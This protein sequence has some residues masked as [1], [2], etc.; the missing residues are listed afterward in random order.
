MLSIQT[1][2]NSLVAQENLSVNSKFQSQTIQRLTSGYRINSAGD[3]AAGLAVANQFRD[4]VAE[5]TQGVRNA[6][7]GVSQL[8]IID[9]GLSNISNI[10]DRLQTLATESSSTSFTGDRSTLNNEY[11]SLL[12][13]I[14]RQSTNIKLN[15]GG[16]LTSQWQVYIGG[17]SSANS[18]AMV[19][20]NLGTSPVDTLGLNLKGTSILG[21][22]TGFANNVVRM[23]DTQAKFDSGTVDPANNEVFT[24]NYTDSTGAAQSSNVTMAARAGGYSGTD[25]V[26]ALNLAIHADTTGVSAQIGGDG[27]LQFIGSGAFTVSYAKNGTVSG[28][29][30]AGAPGGTAVATNLTNS[31]NYNVSKAF[32]PFA[33]TG[34]PSTST[35]LNEVAQFTTGGKNYS[36]TLSSDS[37]SPDYADNISDAITII[38]KQLA[39]SGIVAVEDQSG[40][41][42]SFQSAD[43]FTIAETQTDG[44][45]TGGVT[46]AGSL[47]GASGAVGVT[48]ADPNKSVTGAA[49]SAID[50]VSAALATLGQVQGRVGAGENQL[51]YAISLAQSQITNFDSAQS[52]IRDTDVAAEAANLSKS[53]VLQQASIAAMAQANSAP[54]QVLSL[55]RG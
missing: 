38:N 7:D 35:Y 25:Y 24:I 49:L 33:T 46:Y 19:S 17:A 13:E 55:L 42:I 29:V 3:D 5:L 1:N 26:T 30:V 50:S 48:P 53:Q 23:D 51:N 14:D 45:A 11:Q 21:G 4:S 44:D 12:G 27:T 18:N 34:G 40:A 31:A 43:N 15:S 28:Q 22:G 10:L 9:G 20:V 6:N 36:V 8:Q 16:A 37:G 39:G 32:T 41:N 54:Q 52:Q 2:V 47:F